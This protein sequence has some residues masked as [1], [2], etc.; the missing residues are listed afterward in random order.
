MKSR[1][2]KCIVLISFLIL[3]IVQL[4]LTY[5]TYVL[6]DRD[7]RLKEK[8]L[9]NDEYGRSISEDK[10]YKGGGHILDSLLSEN[11]PY[12]RETY[13][14]NP[15]NFEKAT[16]RVIGSIL[17][18]LKNK[19]TMDSVFRSIVKRNRLDTSLKY[20]LTFESI[21]I[22][23]DGRRDN[24]FV[25]N[26]RRKMNL[27]PG[28]KSPYGFIIDG[29]LEEPNARNMVTHL[30]VSDRLVYDYRITFDL[31]VDSPSR[32]LAVAY[33][34]LPTFSLVALCIFIMVAINYYT[35]IS[36]M[37]QKKETE[38]KSDFLNSIKHE[39]NTPITTIMV[40]S[41][42]LD[43]D[44]VLHDKAR[45]KTLVQIIERQARRLHAHINQMLEISE[46]KNNARFE[47]TDL[48]YEVLTLVND[49]KIKM[50]ASDNLSFDPHGAEILVMLDRFAFTTMLQNML[51]NSY[52]H[53]SNINKTVAI[54][55]T[56]SQ[57]DY[58][59]H[60]KDNGKGIAKSTKTKIFDKFFRADKDVSVPGLGLGLYY[61]KECLDLHS[62]GIEVESKPGIGTEFMVRIPRH[63]KARGQEKY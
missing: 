32:P 38:V 40:A 35:Y 17:S 14:K 6:R 56:E 54:F 47:E 4:E 51:D 21:E 12:L 20:L 29:S 15:E 41:R 24:V 58:V 43:E 53:N 37:R 8:Q 23:F 22:N 18:E 52:K 9:I 7:Y 28:E 62:W 2:Y 26:G 39:F 11:M 30:S 5:N 44:E 36:W 61:V 13:I 42:S 57:D 45:V 59:L 33:Q 34:M 10:L 16:H 27:Y 60:L 31:F 25:Y 48:N 49:Y 3:I 1:I 19:S 46:I 50:M 63:N 55:I